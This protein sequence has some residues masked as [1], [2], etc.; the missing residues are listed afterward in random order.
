MAQVM[1]PD[2]IV[3]VQVDEYFESGWG[4]C[5]CN[6]QSVTGSWKVT[7]PSSSLILSNG[8]YK[9]GGNKYVGGYSP[10][11]LYSTSINGGGTNLVGFVY[12]F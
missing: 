6:K 2:I 11:D 1:G 10:W 7:Y 9:S 3:V 12:S 8:L 5:W 4:S